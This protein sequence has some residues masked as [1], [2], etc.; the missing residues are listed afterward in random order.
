M[1]KLPVAQIDASQNRTISILIGA[2]SALGGIALFMG[3]LHDRKHSKLREE[4]LLLDKE[5]KQIE[6]ER[7]KNG[8][9]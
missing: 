7:K 2:V 9:S 6:L 8:K 3:Y 4:I 5:I 1:T